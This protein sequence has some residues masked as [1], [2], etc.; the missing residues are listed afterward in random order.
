M[1]YYCLMMLLTLRSADKTV[2]H[3]QQLISLHL[4][5]QP[6]FSRG[7]FLLLLPETEVV[8]SRF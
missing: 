7:F 1:P 5:E 3:K 4:K 8:K 6:F 2:L